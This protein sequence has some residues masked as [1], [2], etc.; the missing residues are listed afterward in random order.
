[1][2]TTVYLAL[3][4]FCDGGFS[5]NVGAAAFVVTSV[6]QVG[7]VLVRKLL[8]ERGRLIQGARSAFQTEVAAMDLATE[9]IGQLSSRRHY[10][11]AKR[12]RTQ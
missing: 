5:D 12:Q 10:L 8:G 1:M 3:Q 4:I 6:S 11:N 2:R 9:H 7:D